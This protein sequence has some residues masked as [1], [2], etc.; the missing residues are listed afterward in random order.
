MPHDEVRGRKDRKAA[1][2]RARFLRATV[3]RAALGVGLAVTVACAAT[4]ARAEDDSNESF[5]NKFMRVIGV[6]PGVMKDGVDYN[7][8][9]PL[10]VPPTRDLPPPVAGGAP[11]TANWPKDPD[12]KRRAQAKVEEKVT[13][14]ID[15]VVESSRALRPEELSVPGA[16][17]SRNAPAAGGGAQQPTDTTT[18]KKSIFSFDWF[19]KEEY[20]TFTG[21]PSRSTLTDPPSGYLTPSPDQPYGVGQDKKQYKIPTLGE[22]VEAPR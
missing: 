1:L 11:A 15:Y 12:I 7:E 6:K 22:R 19:K 20:A 17:T 9:S 14:K 4:A 18:Q 16:N 3:L 10:V 5:Y 21:E 13:P 8:R 2:M